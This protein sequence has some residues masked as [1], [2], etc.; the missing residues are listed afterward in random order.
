MSDFEKLGKNLMLNYI[1][2]IQGRF[3]SHVIGFIGS[4][5]IIRILQPIDYGVLSIAMTIPYM[6]GLFGNLGVNTAVTRFSAKYKEVDINK[7]Y[8]VISSGML[9]DFSYGVLLAIIGYL[10]APFIF[11]YIYNKP[12][13]IPYGQLASLYTIPYWGLSSIFSGL[14]G[15]EMTKH[16]SGIWIVHYTLQTI[17]SVGLG[18]T[19]LRIDGVIIGYSLAYAGAIIYGLF[20]LKKYSMLRSFP[21]ISTIKELVHFGFPLVLPGVG[22]TVAGLYNSS[23]VNRILSIFEISNLTASS[24]IG[25]L[26][27]TIF[28][29]LGFALQP[30]FSK[31][32][33]SNKQ[34]V[35]NITNELYKISMITQVPILFGVIFI[36]NQI[37]YLLAG[38][39]YTLAPLLLRL[40]LIGPL[41]STAS[42]GGILAS[43]IL[44][45]G[46]TKTYARI[47]IIGV[48]INS[49]L[50]TILLPSLG[51]LGYFLTGWISWIPGY[52]MSYNVVKNMYKDYKLPLS[53]VWK[54]Y[55]V[56][57]SILFPLFL[58]KSE[59]ALALG[60][61]L[62]LL[63]FK[64]YAKIKIINPKET[65]VLISALEE[66]NLRFLSSFVRF[67][68]S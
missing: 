67:F 36:S 18:I 41:I 20:V 51:Y 64:I 7:A 33:Y 17:F 9:F 8:N 30:I 62:V 24:K 46:Y 29:P 58:V 39:S 57:G 37:I 14:L 65:Q 66:S 3:L 44:Y 50:L 56:S 42:G 10:T 40:S 48:V 1:N 21:S 4:I 26:F 28:N 12:E 35:I 52:I 31:L 63:L 49:V 15:F 32:D 2:L 16:N 5:L 47:R 19:F 34:N 22:G 60:I 53:T 45:G 59:F 68:L 55:L 61:I 38:S 13:I 11:T 23:I 6:V 27:D 43:L 54:V 25:F